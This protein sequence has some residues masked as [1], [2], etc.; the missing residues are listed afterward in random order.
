MER[1]LPET[2][3]TIRFR[4]ILPEVREIVNKK[5]NITLKVS[6]LRR[7]ARDFI[8]RFIQD[9]V[10]TIDLEELNNL[11]ET[12]ELKDN[13][14]LKR[15]DGRLFEKIHEGKSLLISTTCPFAPFFDSVKEG[16]FLEEF[17]RA[18]KKEGIIHPLCIVHQ[19]IREEL[20]SRIRSG[21]FFIHPVLLGTRN[22]LTGATAFSKKE[23]DL[24][25]LKEDSFSE[26]LDNHACVFMVL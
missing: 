16:A 8:R 19:I 22:I 21:P 23:L 10:T 3:L 1:R 25:H 6:S 12:E 11:S 17:E 7:L 14:F 4:P 20:L 24:L 5:E 18:F 15:L 2:D 9:L 13:L 26:L